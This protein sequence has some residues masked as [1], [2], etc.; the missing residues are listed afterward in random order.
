MTPESFPELHAEIVRLQALLDYHE[1]EGFRADL[2]DMG[3]QLLN[4]LGMLLPHQH[5][6][7]TTWTPRQTAGRT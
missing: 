2:T 3:R 5:H 1:F 7:S 4:R 6:R